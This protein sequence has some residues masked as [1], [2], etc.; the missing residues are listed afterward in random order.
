MIPSNVSYCLGFVFQNN[1]PLAL[2]EVEVIF[3]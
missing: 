1:N 3:L 2:P